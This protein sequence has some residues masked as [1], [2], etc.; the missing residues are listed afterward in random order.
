MLRCKRWKSIAHQCIVEG[1]ILWWRRGCS[2]RDFIRRST[3]QSNCDLSWS[4]CKRTCEGC[5]NFELYDDF[6][7]ISNQVK[8]SLRLSSCWTKT[9]RTTPSCTICIYDLSCQNLTVGLTSSWESKCISR[10]YGVT[11]KLANRCYKRHIVQVGNVI[12]IATDIQCVRAKELCRSSISCSFKEENYCL[13]QAVIQRRHN[14]IARDS[15][16]RVQI[17]W[18]RDYCS[19]GRELICWYRATGLLRRGIG[20]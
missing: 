1:N 10:G 15:L 12:I 4:Q 13:M 9:G 8:D 5:F 11:H 7:I 14:L 20:G 2:S 18:S 19:W 17:I 16:D 6:S 3:C